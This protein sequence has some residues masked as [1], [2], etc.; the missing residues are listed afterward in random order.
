MEADRNEI[1]AVH[2]DRQ[3]RERMLLEDG[4]KLIERP[5]DE[6]Y[7][8]QSGEDLFGE[9]RKLLHDHNGLERSHEEADHQNPNADPDSSRH[10]TDLHFAAKLK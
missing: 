2:V 10:E 6:N 7:A 9:P 5:V 8:H 3:R 4:G 1:C